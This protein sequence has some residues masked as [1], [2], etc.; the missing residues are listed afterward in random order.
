M[1]CKLGFDCIINEKYFNCYNREYCESL[2]FP[3]PL[4]YNYDRDYLEVDLGCL[5]SFF[6]YREHYLSEIQELFQEAIEL[7]YCYDEDSKSLTVQVV[8]RIRMH[9]EQKQILRERFQ[10]YGFADAIPLP[11][12]L[13]DN[14]S[15]GGSLL[16]VRF[17]YS[18]H[19][20]SFY[21]RRLYNENGFYEAEPLND[22]IPF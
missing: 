10:N 17:S 21:L 6:K 3:W 8:S 11:F 4:P 7:P 5:H 1:I 18:I 14:M 12:K 13:I 15:W 16:E 20:D 2:A 9:Y 22:S 19:Y